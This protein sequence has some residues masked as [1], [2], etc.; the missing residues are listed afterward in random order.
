[1]GDPLVLVGGTRHHHHI[2]RR[3]N[4]VFMLKEILIKIEILIRHHSYNFFFNRTPIL[5]LWKERTF[6]SLSQIKELKNIMVRELIYIGAEKFFYF[7]KKRFFNNCEQQV[8]IFDIHT[9][10]L[11]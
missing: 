1:M 5:V 9:A 10:L 2:L 8:I 4:E 3:K 6:S 11:G 7:F